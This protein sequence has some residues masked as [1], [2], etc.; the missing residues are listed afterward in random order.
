MHNTNFDSIKPDFSSRSDF[1]LSSGL[2][3]LALSNV[4]NKVSWLPKFLGYGKSSGS[5]AHET[6]AESFKK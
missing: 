5:R 2:V 3:P 6:R 4:H 1:G